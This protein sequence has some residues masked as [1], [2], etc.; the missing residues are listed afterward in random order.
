MPPT[1]DFFLGGVGGSGDGLETLAV[2]EPAPVVPVPELVDVV[3]DVEV[4]T[5]VMVEPPLVMVVGAVITEDKTDVATPVAEA[6]ERGEPFG[7][8]HE[9]VGVDESRQTYRL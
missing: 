2:L 7:S 9:L 4:P 8:F 5:D 1:L 3:L 6:P